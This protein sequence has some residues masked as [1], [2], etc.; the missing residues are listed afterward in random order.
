MGQALAAQ[1]DGILAPFFC[2]K[3]GPDHSHVGIRITAGDPADLK[4]FDPFSAFFAFAQNVSR[5]ALQIKTAFL[6][7][8]VIG[9]VQPVNA[10]PFL[11]FG[12]R[13]IIHDL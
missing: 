12:T 8:P 7:A 10:G 6:F 5:W 4:L 13:D 3:N 1:V 2:Q 9:G 11:I